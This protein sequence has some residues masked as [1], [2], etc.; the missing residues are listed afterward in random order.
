MAVVLNGCGKR[1]P[2]KE[3]RQKHPFP[4][5]FICL[6]GGIGRCQPGDVYAQCAVYYSDG[7]TACGESTEYWGVLCRACAVKGGFLW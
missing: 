1:T 3:T 4:F 6:K 2:S 7:W 5:T